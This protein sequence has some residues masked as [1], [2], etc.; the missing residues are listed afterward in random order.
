MMNKEHEAELNLLSRGAKEMQEGGSTYIFLP[1]LTLP[2]NCTPNRVDA[3]L[4]LS[5]ITVNDYPT[6][7]FFSQK[8][9][10]SPPPA[11][12]LNWNA[13]NSVIFQRT[14]F[15][16]SWSGVVNEGRPTEIIAQHLSAFR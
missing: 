4:R 7:L 1:N 16:F 15:A 10:V 14:W 5:S 3:L 13:I 2:S 6:R 11:K 8:I 12:P 9:V